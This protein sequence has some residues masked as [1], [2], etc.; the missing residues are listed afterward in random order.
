MREPRGCRQE[1]N[2][3]PRDK[4]DVLHDPQTS[5]T[6]SSPVLRPRAEVEADDG[7]QDMLDT[8][9]AEMGRWR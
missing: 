3:R 8:E 2:A 1:G 7:G 6:N 4:S 9:A 5:L